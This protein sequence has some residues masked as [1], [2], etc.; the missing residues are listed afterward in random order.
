[1]FTRTGHVLMRQ[2]YE[3]ETE[4][5]R[6][7]Y[8][9]KKN[10]LIGAI[11]KTAETQAL[12][13]KLIDENRR[14][15][16]SSNLL[17]KEITDQQAVIETNKIT[18]NKIES[19]CTRINDKKELLKL[20]ITKIE[21]K[22]YEKMQEELSAQETLQ[23]TQ[24]KVSQALSFLDRVNEKIAQAKLDLESVIKDCAIRLANISEKEEALSEFEKQLNQKAL[25]NGQEDM[26]LEK[27]RERLNKR[28]EELNLN[29]KL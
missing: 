23:I 18:L 11:Q 2:K 1:M 8:E 3:A 15:V 10:G 6:S 28:Y 13:T 29:I 19:D 20:E 7:E 16:E 21:S 14:L 26:R 4:S 17:K 12:N 5:I 27:Y 24:S 25:N 22:R 9:E